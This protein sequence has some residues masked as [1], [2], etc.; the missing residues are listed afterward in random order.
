MWVYSWMI[1]CMEKVNIQLKID[2]HMKGISKMMIY[3]DM[4]FAPGWM[5]KNTKENGNI[6]KWKEREHL[7]GLIE[8]AIKVYILK[9]TIFLIKR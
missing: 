9:I 1:K 4:E 7:P 3:K 2:I 8:N 6:I 5:A